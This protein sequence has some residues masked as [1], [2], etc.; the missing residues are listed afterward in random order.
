MSNQAIVLNNFKEDV[1]SHFEI[2]KD[3][4]KRDKRS[5]AEEWTNELLRMRQTWE[6]ALKS[7]PIQIMTG[8]FARGW[9]VALDTSESKEMARKRLDYIN[10]ILGP[11]RVIFVKKGWM[12][13]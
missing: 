5:E 4:I 6:D 12:K 7:K 3:C 2:I 1:N 13:A 8:S 11:I 9:K 10:E